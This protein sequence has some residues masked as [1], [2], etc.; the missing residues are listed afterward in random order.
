MPAQTKKLVSSI[1]LRLRLLQV[2]FSEVCIEVG[3]SF[4]LGILHWIIPVLILYRVREIDLQDTLWAFLQLSICIQMSKGRRSVVL[5]GINDH[6][7]SGEDGDQKKDRKESAVNA[8]EASKNSKCSEKLAPE[9]EMRMEPAALSSAELE[10]RN[11]RRAGEA[12]LQALPEEKQAK[13]TSLLNRE[14][15]TEIVGK[16]IKQ[17]PKGDRS[18]IVRHKDGSIHVEPKVKVHGVPTHWTPKVLHEKFC[19]LDPTMLDAGLGEDMI[20][21]DLIRLD[22]KGVQCKTTPMTILDFPI[23]ERINQFIEGKLQ[24]ANLDMIFLARMEEESKCVKGRNQVGLGNYLRALEMAGLTKQSIEWVLTTQI[25]ASLAG[26]Q[27]DQCVECVRIDN[28]RYASRDNGSGGKTWIAEIIPL[29]KAHLCIYM[30]S[31]QSV[32][33]LL[34]SKNATLCLGPA[35]IEVILEHREAFAVRKENREE[36]RPAQMQTAREMAASG[37]LPRTPAWLSMITV[38]KLQVEWTGA[39]KA[40]LSNVAYGKAEK[41]VRDMLGGEM[42]GILSVRLECQRAN[43]IALWNGSL[44]IVVADVS[45]RIKPGTKSGLYGV[46]A[47]Q[48]YEKLQSRAELKDSKGR[49]ICKSFGLRNGYAIEVEQENQAT[50][51]KAARAGGV[52]KVFDVVAVQEVIKSHLYNGATICLAATDK[53][54]E[55]TQLEGD[56][57]TP[58]DQL[59]VIDY[60]GS[61]FEDALHLVKNMPGVTAEILYPALLELVRV[62]QITIYTD[63]VN[64]KEVYLFLHV[65]RDMDEPTDETKNGNDVKMEE[66][67]KLDGSGGQ[68][69]ETMD[70]DSTQS[71][72]SASN[73]KDAQR[74]I[75][76]LRVKAESTLYSGK[77]QLETVTAALCAIPVISDHGADLSN[78]A[79]ALSDEFTTR[80]IGRVNELSIET[81][82]EVDVLVSQWSTRLQQ[83]C[84]DA[85]ILQT[86]WEKNCQERSQQVH[87]RQTLEQAM[88]TMEAQLQQMEKEAPK[89]NNNQRCKQ[90]RADLKRG[91]VALKA[92]DTIMQQMLSIDLNLASSEDLLKHQQV[93]STLEHQIQEGTIQLQAL[94]VQMATLPRRVTDDGPAY[95]SD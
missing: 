35:K 68:R 18:L 75:E 50:W 66:Q 44:S 94:S 32:T 47:D 43:N 86:A 16:F 91:K 87:Q 79:R 56:R 37:K 24:N 5:K 73:L 15:L 29:E 9:M 14:V 59:A 69:L 10:L 70:V 22:E 53:D 2:L 26:S 95:E 7:N 76:T 38:R 41:A 21:Q 80:L 64:G 1:E 65:W 19:E 23:T 49:V 11:Y 89:F 28:V 67:Q 3:Y 54:G 72:Q 62:H 60:H 27:W 81:S 34:R 30:K 88:A 13:A 90:W 4:F 77:A 93:L 74:Q 31:E 61:S 51:M 33:E 46:W 25:E 84:A 12:V 55:K 58:L 45:A 92:T 52:E 57:V 83:F 8:G 82:E 85:A 39:G 40:E 42:F 6:I 20:A 48:I 78:R 63:E 17:S 71:S 36:T